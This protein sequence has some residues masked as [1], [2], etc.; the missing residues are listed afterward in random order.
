VEHRPDHRLGWAREEE[1]ALLTDLY[2]LT[3][4]QSYW[5]RGMTERAT[6][7]LFVRD[8]PPTRRFLVACGLEHALAY[9]EAL[10]F[11]AAGIDGLR[12]LGRFDPAFLDWLG[13]LRFTGDVWAMPEGEVAFA[14]EPLLRV[15]A[16]LP[17][18]QLVETYL[19]NAVL[20]PTG[21]ASK[22]ARCVL[23]ADGR[24]VVDFSPRR[25]HGADAALR[26]ARAAWIAGCVGTSNVLAG[27]RYGIPVYGTMAHSYVMAFDDEEAAFRA[28]A[29][30]FPDAAVLLVDTYDVEEGLRRA[31]VV[32]RELA[33]R[34]RRL[35]GVRIDSGDLV[36]LA[37]RAREVLDAAGLADARVLVSGDLNEHRIAGLV[38]AGAP[39]DAFGVGTEL[40]VVADAP[41]LG[42]VYK[43]AEYAG[44]GRAKRSPAKRT[45]P[46][47]KQVWRRQ[48][49][50]D[51]LAPEGE[52][53]PDAR[54]LLVPVM[55]AGRI[56][57]AEPLDE[58]RRRCAARLAALPGPLRRL[59]P[60]GPDEPSRPALSP[61]LRSDR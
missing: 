22:A 55:R 1:L 25:D 39:V 10:R 13:E 44:R 49:F 6:F 7:E 33:A 46:G 35:R 54:P 37:R 48:G 42:G 50:E 57:H 2:Q 26:A 19:L 43:L 56:V 59:E 8:L 20:Y 12:R 18:A 30:E 36:A 61:A 9:L 27:I 29:E 32:G 53:V 23:A 38:A 15:T 4:V 28:Y 16:P 41:A 45:I 58:A 60:R 14:E 34:G 3:M 51:V 24:D 17:E 5:R 11:D 52:E 47:R 31:A 21:V 40:G